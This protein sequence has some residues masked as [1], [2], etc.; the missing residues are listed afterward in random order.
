MGNREVT[1][2]KQRKQVVGILIGGRRNRKRKRGKRKRKRGIWTIFLIVA[3][4]V[5]K[6]YGKRRRK[7]KSKESFRLSQIH[8]SHLNLLEKR[9]KRRR[10]SGQILMMSQKNQSLRDGRGNLGGKNWKAAI[11]KM[12]GRNGGSR[13]LRNTRQRESQSG[14]RGPRNKRNNC[15]ILTTRATC[16]TLATLM[17]FWWTPRQRNRSQR[18]K[19]KR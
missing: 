7:R 19:A 8:L 11:P 9:A 17:S 6:K 10:K 2:G 15:L 12:S 3:Q 1:L 4:I 13:S 16:R 18:K 14:Q 5:K